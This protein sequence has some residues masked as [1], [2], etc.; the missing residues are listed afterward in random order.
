[1]DSIPGAATRRLTQQDLKHLVC[2]VCHAALQLESN[3]IACTGCAR[4]YPIVDGLAALLPDR[5][6]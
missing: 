5:A 3:A 1:M 4:R 6:L 2:P